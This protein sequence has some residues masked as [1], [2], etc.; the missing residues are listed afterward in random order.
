MLALRRF[1]EVDNAHRYHLVTI[2][3][4]GRLQLFWGKANEH[5]LTGA[6]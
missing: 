4:A 3:S 6:G 2:K 1:E 5:R